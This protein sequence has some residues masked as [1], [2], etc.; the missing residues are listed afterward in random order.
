MQ[1]LHTA[2]WLLPITSP[3]ISNGAVLV[4]D[5]VILNFG[6]AKT[7]LENHPDAKII[8]HE[9]SILMPGL[10]NVHTHLELSMMRGAIP[11]GLD[12]ADWVFEAITGRFKYSDEEIKSSC[13]NAVRQLEA[14]GTVAIGDIAN[15]SGVS[16][17]LLKDSA[18]WA[19]VF[20]EVTGFQKS[21]IEVKYQEFLPRISRD[22]EPRIRQ[23][24]CSHAPYSVS[25]PLLEQV[26]NFV[27]DNHHV[28]TIHLSE[29]KDE[30]RFLQYGDG[31]M[32]AMIEKIGRWDTEW[33]IPN[34][35]PTQYLDRLNLLHGK[36]LAIHLVHTDNEDLALLKAR[37]VSIG[38]CP[39]SNVKINVGGTAPLRKY[40][41]AGINVALGTDSLASNDDLNLWNEM[42]FLQKQN[43]W[44]KEDALLGIATING[45]KAL[46][47]EQFLGSVESGKRAELIVVQSDS[48]IADPLKYLSL[49][50]K[51]IH[52]IES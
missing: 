24:L 16:L 36:M 43:P 52:K 23:T 28:T 49:A 10:V 51:R 40:L 1:I 12:F 8:P 42:A 48:K 6:S 37:G 29:S 50:N 7:L 19:V 15:N 9:N 13:E 18:L 32:K 17:P 25:K 26:G 4:R 3:P 46:G 47:F 20:N 41:D 5:G 21:L 44:L 34:S 45:A 11:E 27:R 39:R 35:T 22:L 38:L 30:L 2:Q 14:C 33:E 31:K